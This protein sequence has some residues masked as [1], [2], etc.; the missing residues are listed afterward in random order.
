MRRVSKD[1]PGEISGKLTG[2]ISYER[3]FLKEE[4]FEKKKDESWGLFKLTQ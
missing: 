2:C 4:I 1:I 3:K